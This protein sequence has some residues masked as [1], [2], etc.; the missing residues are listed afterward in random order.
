MPTAQ[1]L[2]LL[3][4]PTM[5]MVWPVLPALLLRLVFLTMRLCCPEL[6]VLLL[7]LVLLVLLW[8]PRVKCTPPARARRLSGM[9]TAPP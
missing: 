8:S 2:L 9:P 6:L 5:T 3:L 4:L 7:P 1:L